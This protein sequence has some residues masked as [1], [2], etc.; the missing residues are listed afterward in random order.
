MERA[1]GVN[2][3]EFFDRWVYQSGHPSYEMSWTWQKGADGRGMLRI[4]LKQTQA[5]APF[6]TPL[7]VEISTGKGSHR[8]MIRPTGRETIALIPQESNPTSV[9]LDPD[10]QILKE[11]VMK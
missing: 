7:S 1:S 5:D 9:Q 11:V 3:K 4:H 2:L 6:L 8:A 10:E